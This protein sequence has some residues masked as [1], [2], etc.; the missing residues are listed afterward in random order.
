MTTNGLLRRT[1]KWHR[2]LSILS[3][4]CVHVPGIH[5]WWST[6]PSWHASLP[7]ALVLLSKKEKTHSVFNLRCGTSSEWGKV[8]KS[9]SSDSNRNNLGL[10]G[11]DD[12]L[13]LWQELQFQSILSAH[14]HL[15]RLF[16]DATLPLK[17]HFFNYLHVKFEVLFYL[18]ST[19]KADLGCQRLELCVRTFAHHHQVWCSGQIPGS[20]LLFLTS[21]PTPFLPGGP[22]CLGTRWPK[23]S[24]ATW[25]ERFTKRNNPKGH[26]ESTEHC[27][28]IKLSTLAIASLSTQQPS[29]SKLLVTSSTSC[30][31]L[32]FFPSERYN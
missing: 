32:F 23:W 15:S 2:L 24:A 12:L 8:C 13:W 9:P 11:N 16:F 6:L 30:A 18:Y 22:V 7:Q 17:C 19:I 14:L 20:I 25:G 31:S 10:F 28:T 3:E 26:C 27:L 1:F 5:L 4:W 29:L 21:P